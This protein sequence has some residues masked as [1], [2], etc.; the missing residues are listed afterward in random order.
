MQTLKREIY[1]SVG[2][3]TR[4]ILYSDLFIKVDENV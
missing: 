2:R 4:G 3:R 1:I